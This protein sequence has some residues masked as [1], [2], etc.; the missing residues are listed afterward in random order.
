MGIPNLD[1]YIL[2]REQWVPG[3]IEDLFAFFS[4][5]RNL[6]AITPPWLGFQIIPPVPAEM[7]AGTRIDYRIR[8]H[9][10]PMRWV[11][12]IQTWQPPREFVDVQLRGP[13]SSWE[14]THRFE[15]VDGGTVMRDTVRYS[16]PFGPIGRLAHAW[17]VKSDLE[18]IF[19]HR[20]SRVAELFG[21]CSGRG[22][23]STPHGE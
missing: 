18:A 19:N 14:H 12:E 1:E 4:E 3:P 8:V 23:D 20:A 9:G 6:Q 17:V 5:A 22:S 2:Q 15:S 11:S 13:Y 7:R 21:P 16:L 10:F